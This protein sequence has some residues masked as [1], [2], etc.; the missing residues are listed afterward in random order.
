[1]IALIRECIC[2]LTRYVK[3]ASN[4]PGASRGS[5]AD[6]RFANLSLFPTSEP[7]WAKRK[8][9]LRDENV[10]K[11]QRTLSFYSLIA[12]ADTCR[13]RS[14]CKSAICNY[15]LAVLQISHKTVVQPLVGCNVH[16]WSSSVFHR[17][18]QGLQSKPHRRI[19]RNS[20]REKADDADSKSVWQIAGIPPAYDSR[21]HFVSTFT[22]YDRES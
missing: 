22:R 19:Y 11:L 17:R 4:C 6:Y 21:F 7:D 12:I 20:S 9:R 15:S 13:N 2:I 18:H 5:S 3:F 8:N 16:F 14:S 10:V 1:M